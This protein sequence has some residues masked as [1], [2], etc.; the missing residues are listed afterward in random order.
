MFVELS[1][2][3]IFNST[4]PRTLVAQWGLWDVMLQRTLV[5]FSDKKY[6]CLFPSP[7]IHTELDYLREK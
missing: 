7:Q 6:G 5:S 3:D 1:R 4:V 2:S